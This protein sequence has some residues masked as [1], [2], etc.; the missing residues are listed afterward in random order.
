MTFWRVL[1]TPFICAVFVLMRFFREP[2]PNVLGLQVA[3]FGVMLGCF[4]GALYQ[5]GRVEVIGGGFYRLKGEWLTL[6]LYLA[7]FIIAYAEGVWRAV[8]PDTF[9]GPLLSLSFLF[10]FCSSA[11][12]FC[13]RSIA[14]LGKTPAR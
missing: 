9:E 1:I 8:T 11:G 2:L 5:R 7:L 14:I 10:I 4:I 13:G 3:L 12:V 6:V